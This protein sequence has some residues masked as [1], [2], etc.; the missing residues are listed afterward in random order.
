MMQ[1]MGLRLKA[2]R[3]QSNTNVIQFHGYGNPT[4]RLPAQAEGAPRQAAKR[5]QGASAASKPG[6]VQKKAP[7]AKKRKVSSGEVPAAGS[8]VTTDC[9][10][11]SLQDYRLLSVLI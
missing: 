3:L 9:C 1:Q 7:A 10:T 11:C 5:K 2:L 8:H 6:A 4:G